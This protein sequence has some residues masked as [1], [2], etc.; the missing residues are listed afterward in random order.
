MTCNGF[1]IEKYPHTYISG[2]FFIH[3]INHV[4][5]VYRKLVYCKLIPLNNLL[6]KRSWK[7]PVKNFNRKTR[8]WWCCKS[9][10]MF[11]CVWDHTHPHTQKKLPS[12]REKSLLQQ[13]HF[14]SNLRV[15]WALFY[16][17]NFIAFVVISFFSNSFLVMVLC[18][19]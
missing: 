13:T 1:V 6:E 17:K 5:K 12:S 11:C 8:F 2:I 7:F 18:I 16:R 3:S 14:Y 10:S 4:W 15:V 9:F 19:Q